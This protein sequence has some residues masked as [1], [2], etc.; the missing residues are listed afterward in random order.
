MNAVISAARMIPF[1]AR[2]PKND[3]VEASANW[4]ESASI[5]MMGPSFGLLLGGSDLVRHMM[6]GC[7][8]TQEKT[9]TSGL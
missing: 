6:S 2:A 1:R 4:F 9:G 7:T 8:R 5:F 3:L